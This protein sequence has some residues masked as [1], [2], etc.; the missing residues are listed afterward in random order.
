MVKQYGVGLELPFEI[1]Q[2]DG[3]VDL[4]GQLPIVEL[5]PESFFFGKKDEFLEMLK[6]S[7]VPVVIHSV[8][9]S[10]GSSGEFHQKHFNQIKQVM[11]QVNTVFYSDHLCF[12]KFDGI[13]IGQLTTLPWT[14]Q[15]MDGVCDNISKIQDQTQVPFLIENI[16]NR[17]VVPDSAYS[18]TEF[19]NRILEKTGCKMIM[20]LANTYINSVNFGFDPYKWIDEINLDFVEGVH[21]AGGDEEDGVLYDSHGSNI[22]APVWDLYAYLAAKKTPQFT[23]VERDQNIP[24]FEELMHEVKVANGILEKSA[25]PGLSESIG[26]VRREAR[27][28]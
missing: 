16:T 26:Q 18:E 24:T 6:K 22:P 21:L 10:I 11:D 8:E 2:R 4:V 12:T 14:K 23:I 1:A 15:I 19:I 20:D 17:F 3:V 25:M 28:L 5:I 7:E 27:S 9:M 13:E